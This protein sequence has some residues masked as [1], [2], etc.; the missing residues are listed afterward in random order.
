M[1]L[2][3]KKDY[4]KAVSEIENLKLKIN[5]LKKKIEELNLTNDNL[6]RENNNLITKNKLL[7]SD[8]EKS[9][10]EI[11]SLNL[12][13]AELEDKSKHSYTLKR[14]GSGRPPKTQTMKVKR[15][16]TSYSPVRNY[17]NE[18]FNYEES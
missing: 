4:E 8:N 5:D 13:V 7:L 11:K 3:Y 15:S 17:I 14:V 2:F 6:T 1:K 12:K 10:D 18:E 16:V 9:I